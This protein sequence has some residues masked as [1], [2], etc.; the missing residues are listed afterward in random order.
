MLTLVTVGTVLALC[1]GLADRPIEALLTVARADAIHAVQ[2]EAVPGA[3]ILIFPGAGL[4]LWAKEAS[5]A[6]FCLKGKDEVVHVFIF[7]SGDSWD[8]VCACLFPRLQGFL[9]T[10]G[11]SPLR[12]E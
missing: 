12:T 4:A 11:Q 9:G 5:T 3:H 2:T 7:C 8:P 6:R 10:R 1:A